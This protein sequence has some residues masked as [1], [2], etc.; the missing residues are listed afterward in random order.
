M[1][2]IFLLL[3]IVTAFSMNAFSQTVK[4]TDN[5]KQTTIDSKKVKKEPSAIKDSPKADK[6]AT[7]P[8][9]EAGKAKEKSVLTNKNAEAVKE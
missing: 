5:S 4:K 8:P 1:K 9:T 6:T 3:V 2:E 7:T